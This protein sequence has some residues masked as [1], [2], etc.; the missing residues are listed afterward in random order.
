M[1]NGIG[2]FV[3]KL[4]WL[5]A[6]FVDLGL[7]HLFLGLCDLRWLLNLLCFTFCWK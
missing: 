6:V 2:V 7:L 5:F 3:L 1:F 4:L